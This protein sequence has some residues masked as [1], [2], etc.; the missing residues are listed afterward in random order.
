MGHFFL[1]MALL[2]TLFQLTPRLSLFIAIIGG[3]G[4]FYAISAYNID[5]RYSCIQA[6]GLVLKRIRLPVASVWENDIY[7]RELMELQCIS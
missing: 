1:L 6:M 2:E 4:I 7:V 3:T 5:V